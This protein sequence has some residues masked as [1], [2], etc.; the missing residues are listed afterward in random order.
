M[1]SNTWKYFAAR[2][3]V[4]MY[5]QKFMDNFPTLSSQMSSCNLVNHS[6]DWFPVLFYYN[7]EL[8]V[9]NMKSREGSD[10]RSKCTDNIRSDSWQFHGK[11]GNMT[12]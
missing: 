7:D 3:N 2:I 6:L 5:T 11:K 9:E 1:Y 4:A 8:D 12:F 10:T